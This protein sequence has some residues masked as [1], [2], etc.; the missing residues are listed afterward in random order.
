MYSS[1][2]NFENVNKTTFEIN[3]WNIKGFKWNL[4][5]YF[6]HAIEFVIQN[7]CKLPQF[8]MFKSF[9]S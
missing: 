4:N 1:N 3:L 5:S 2:F 8:C 7:T 6:I 9:Y